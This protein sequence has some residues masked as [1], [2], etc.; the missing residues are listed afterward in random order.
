MEAVYKLFWNKYKDSKGTVGEKFRQCFLKRRCPRMSEHIMSQLVGVGK[1]TGVRTRDQVLPRVSPTLKACF[2]IKALPI[3]I[4]VKPHSTWG[5]HGE[6][7]IPDST[8][9]RHGDLV[10]ALW[11]H[12]P[13]LLQLLE[14]ESVSIQLQTRSSP[15]FAR[16][17][18]PS[19]QADA[20]C[21]GWGSSVPS[22]FSRP[23]LLLHIPLPKEMQ[24]LRSKCW[25]GQPSV[26][27]I[28][29]KVWPLAWRTGSP[30]GD[31]EIER[32]WKG[33]AQDAVGDPQWPNQTN[34]LVRTS[35]VE[36]LPCD[37]L[38]FPRGCFSIYLFLSQ[39][40]TTLSFGIGGPRALSS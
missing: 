19:H 4:L 30:M 27:G 24:K 33:E 32:C 37:H 6:C 29:V 26:A 28:Y 34:G 17:P 10:H 16:S 11:S 13:K 39:H 2:Q 12:W 31:S 40:L 22:P 1:C 14:K 38:Q 35:P 3:R 18:G 25:L 20:L 5:S 23:Q 7:Q 8:D 15:G 9:T 36:S 21:T